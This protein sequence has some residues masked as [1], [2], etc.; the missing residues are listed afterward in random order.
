MNVPR[1]PL[2]HKFGDRHFAYGACTGCNS[3]SEFA[4]LLSHLG[5]D[6]GEGKYSITIGGCESFTFEFDQSTEDEASIEGTAATGVVLRA[7][8]YRIHEVL[9]RGDVRHWIEITD[10]VQNRLEYLHHEWPEA[11]A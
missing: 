5:L 4:A 3:Q 1:C 9:R 2:E 8:A 6:V 11:N 7:D 10:A